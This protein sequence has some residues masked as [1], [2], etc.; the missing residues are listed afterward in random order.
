MTGLIITLYSRARYVRRCFDWL[1]RAKLDGVKVILVDD[2]A[3]EAMPEFPRA[4]L[5]VQHTR[6]A[7]IKAALMSGIDAAIE[8]G[9][10]EFVILDSDAIVRPNFIEVLR[11]LKVASN[12][13]I[14][15]GF[16]TAAD[17]DRTAR[18][19][20]G[21]VN[22]IFDLN[23]Y[24]KYVLPA[25]LSGA[26][27][28]DFE[29][30]KKLMVPLAKPSVVQH[31][32]YSSSLGHDSTIPD[33]SPDFKEFRLPDVTLALVKASSRVGVICRM[34]IEFGGV[35]EVEDPREL[36]GVVRTSHVLAVN[37]H[38]YILHPESW[39]DQWMNYAR[40]GDMSGFC[41]QRMDG[42]GMEA[43]GP[44]DGFTSGPLPFGFSGKETDLS[45]LP[46]FL[47]MSSGI[48]RAYSRHLDRIGFYKM[49]KR[50]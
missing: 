27:N 9:C 45:H 21:G 28:W 7:G 6:N 22:M 48:P 16:R 3:V 34:N 25:L 43:K 40:V 12:A 46:R 41:L 20:C 42:T 24:K 35:V 17:G 2:G 32:G 33:H 31:I 23:A 49:K 44:V 36:P 47:H 1:G 37:D 29:A 30:T 39:Q 10:D 15:S 26:Q 11:A 38:G 5:I 14:V 4:D 50:K 8:M 18:K 19:S 13:P